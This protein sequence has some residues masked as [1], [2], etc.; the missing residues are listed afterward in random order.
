M[1]KETYYSV[2]RD[3]VQCQKRPSTVSKETYYSV[4]RDLLH[5][6]KQTIHEL[7]I[8]TSAP[9]S[10]T[11]CAVR[12]REGERERGREGEREGG[13]EGSWPGRGGAKGQRLPQ[14]LKS[15]CPSIFPI[16][17]HSIRGTFQNAC[18]SR[19]FSLFFLP[20]FFPRCVPLV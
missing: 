18:R 16:G 1:S 14:I 8:R 5:T 20:L 13:R 7:S 11:S 6:Y 12:G 9:R 2:K 15:Q 19:S 10:Q 4:K 3:L 17:S